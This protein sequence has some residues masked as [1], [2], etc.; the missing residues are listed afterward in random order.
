[1]SGQRVPKW[2][3]LNMG[4]DSEREFKQEKRYWFRRGMSAFIEF[5]S[6]CAYIPTTTYVKYNRAMT[7]LREV[8]KE[9]SFR[10]WGR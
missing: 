10:E 3:L 4:V 5:S 2:V 9:L 8:R 6:G 7:L 1:M